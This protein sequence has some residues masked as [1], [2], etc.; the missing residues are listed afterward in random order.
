MVAKAEPAV[1]NK[2]KETNRQLR[3]ARDE[4]ASELTTL[5]RSTRATRV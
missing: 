1:L 3:A 5:Q 2:L 4:L